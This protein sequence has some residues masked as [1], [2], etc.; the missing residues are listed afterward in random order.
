MRRDTKIRI[1]CGVIAIIIAEI[2]N[3][4]LPYSPKWVA[5]VLVGFLLPMAIFL[6]LSVISILRWGETITDRR[7][8]KKISQ[9]IGTIR[10]NLPKSYPGDTGYQPFE[11]DNND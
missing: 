11:N 2:V 10:T 7:K 9:I 5:P 8:S 4:L 3:F 6:T 1:I